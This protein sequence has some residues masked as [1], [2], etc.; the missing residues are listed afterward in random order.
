MACESDLEVLGLQPG[1]EAIEPVRLAAT[2]IVVTITSAWSFKK[3][4]RLSLFFTH[5]LS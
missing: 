2:L 3:I 5:W 4:R 1:E